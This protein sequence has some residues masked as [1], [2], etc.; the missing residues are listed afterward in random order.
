MKKIIMAIS[1]ALALVCCFSATACGIKNN[2][3]KSKSSESEISVTP[4][5]LLTSSEVSLLSVDVDGNE[6]VSNKITARL[7]PETVLDTYVTWAVAW[8]DD[9]P[10]KDKNISDYIKISSD[11]QGSL[12]AEVCCYKSFR[13]SEA[14]LTCTTRQ[15]G[16][17]AT[18]RIIF[19]GLPSS[20]SITAEEGL[21]QYNLGVDT[22]DLL[23]VGNTYSFGLSLDNVFHD[24]GDGYLDSLTVSVSG[25][26]TAT[27]MD[28]YSPQ[29]RG[30]IWKSGTEKIVDLKSIVNNFIS[31]SIV[32][33]K[34]QISV[35]KG[36]YNYY[37]SYTESGSDEQGFGYRDYYTGKLKSLNI[38]SD[39]N[40]PYF[41]VT[42][43]SFSYNLSNS[44]YKFFIADSLT[45]V[46]LSKGEITF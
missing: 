33:N 38:D 19:E 9:A 35:L 45:D 8:K 37:E 6:C 11:S 41:I 32:E 14:T 43:K 13:G 34:L 17:T 31:V 29:G 36:F 22:V 7:Y 24:V 4:Q 23:L 44:Y 40:L 21:N 12:T 5:L 27:C 28:Y 26:G 25:V 10:L 39:G 2:K 18:A 30:G 15:G 3:D 16:L 1:L 46:E 20:L 42:V